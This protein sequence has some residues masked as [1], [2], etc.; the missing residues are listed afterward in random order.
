[1][2]LGPPVATEPLHDG[3]L[4]ADPAREAEIGYAILVTVVASSPG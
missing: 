3:D 1:M 4:A 2:W